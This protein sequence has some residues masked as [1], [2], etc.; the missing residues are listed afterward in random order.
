[1]SETTQRY[2]AALFGARG[3]TPKPSAQPPKP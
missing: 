1:M 3:M 2:A